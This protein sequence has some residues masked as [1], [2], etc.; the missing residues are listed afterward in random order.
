MKGRRGREERQREDGNASVAVLFGL[1]T[2]TVLVVAPILSF[3]L[4]V[5]ALWC[6]GAGHYFAALLSTLAAGLCLWVGE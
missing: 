1:F 4:G 5:L 2:G 3:P 6:V